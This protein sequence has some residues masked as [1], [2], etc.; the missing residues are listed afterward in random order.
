MINKLYLNKDWLQSKYLNEQLSITQIKLLCGIKGH[1][2]T[3]TRYLKK[4]GIVKRSLSLSLHLSK[5]NHYNPSKKAIEWIEG[6]LLGDGC[7]GSKSIYSAYFRYSSKYPEYIQYVSDTL[8][9]FGIKRLGKIRKYYNKVY[10]FYSYHYYSKYYE[11]LYSLY[12]KWYPSR[13]KIIPPHLKITPITLKQWYIGDGC[14]IKPLQTPTRHERPHIELF[15]F[16]FSS[17]SVNRLVKQLNKI[18]IKATRRQY[19]NSIRI[20]T[21]SIQ[22][23]FNYIGKSPVDCYQYK[24]NSLSSLCKK[25]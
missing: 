11:E 14:L 21:L 7:L 8:S 9:S 2:D 23:F 17:L 10:N 5:A 25:S 24:F 3:I 22:N 1:G 12:L 16:A 19:N 20:S 18:G 6:E 4:F 13:K 15:P